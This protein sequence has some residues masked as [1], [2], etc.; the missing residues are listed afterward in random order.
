MNMHS[1]EGI[2]FYPPTHLVVNQIPVLHGF[3]G[4][5]G[6]V[7]E[8]IYD[9]LNCSLKNDIRNNVIENRR[10]I[11]SCYGQPLKNL[12]LL[13]QIHGSQAIIVDD[14]IG[15]GKADAMV[16]CKKDIVLGIQT[17]DCVPIL[18]YSKEGVIGAVHGGWKSLVGG[19]I[20]HTVRKM[21]QLGAKRENII[22]SI[23]PCIHQ[24]SYETGQDFYDHLCEISLENEIF[25]ISDSNSK[26]FFD[27]PRYARKKLLKSEIANIIDTQEDT[28]TN[29]NL[30][31]SRRYSLHQG[32]KYYGSQLSVIM[33]T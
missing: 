7:S 21:T 30:Y 26:Y 14:V 13:Q 11:V 6:G 23:G 12:M 25:F 28:Y 18:L 22:A 2:D 3:F 29:P 4:R 20:E 9:S 32:N 19:I 8:G 17:A 10:R 1:W 15:N 27:L 5:K 31:F 16:T 33:L 24:S